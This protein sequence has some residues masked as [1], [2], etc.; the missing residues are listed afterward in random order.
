MQGETTE[1]TI[2]QL[3]EFVGRP[4]SDLPANVTVHGAWP[5]VD[6]ESMEITGVVL[7]DAAEG[8]D[9]ADLVDGQIVTGEHY[10]AFLVAAANES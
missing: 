3:N 6:R 5:V 8:Y 2:E 10:V 1:M 4:Y 7:G 9:T